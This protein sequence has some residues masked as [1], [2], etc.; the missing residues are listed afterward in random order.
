MANQRRRTSFEALL[1]QEI[2][3]WAGRDWSFNTVYL[4]GGTPSILAAETLEGLLGQVSKRLNL[5]TDCRLYLEANPEDI[6]NNRLALWRD[7]GVDTLSLGVQ[8][9]DDQSLSFLGRRHT[10]VQ[11]QKA[12][13]LAVAAGFETVSVDLIYGLPGQDL[14][15]WRRTLDIA[16]ALGPQHFSCY[17]LEIHQRTPFGQRLKRGELSEATEPRQADLF[18][19]T[20]QRLAEAGWQGYEVSNFARRPEHRSLHNSKY[21]DHTPYLGLGPSAHSFAGLQRWWNHRHL[22]VW[23]RHLR[24]GDDPKQETE[25]LTTEQLA[26]ERLMLGFRTYEG[27]ELREFQQRYGVDLMALNEPRID[28]LRS[29]KLLDKDPHFL[30]PTLE[31]LAVAD[32]LAAGF[33]VTPE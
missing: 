29:S 23:A 33:E 21:W 22:E 19:L 17:Q 8:A 31:G 12:V 2:E 28:Q 1:G 24:A 9:F 6:D 11:A 26:L 20:H 15:A 25:E 16:I 7:L 30:R 10:A 4:E 27:I 5:E 14:E 3:H 13:R 18:M 32:G